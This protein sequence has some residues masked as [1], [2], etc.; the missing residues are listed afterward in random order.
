MRERR[1]SFATAW[2][3]VH[4]GSQMLFSGFFLPFGKHSETVSGNPKSESKESDNDCGKSRC[5]SMPLLHGVSEATD[6]ARYHARLF[7]GGLAFIFLPYVLYA[8]MKR[9]GSRDKRNKDEKANSSD[10][11]SND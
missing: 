7:F 3:T 5:D 2:T 4:V 10:D 6:R 9:W 1:R 11:S 8:L